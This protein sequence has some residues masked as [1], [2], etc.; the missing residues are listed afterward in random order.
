[1]VGTYT[2]EPLNN[3]VGEVSV[4]SEIT[5]VWLISCCSLSPSVME[6]GGQGHSSVSIPSWRDS[7]Q[8]VWST[9]SRLSSLPAS[10]EL[11]SFLTL[12]VPPSSC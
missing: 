1:M 12:Y 4:S 8:R 9:S 6:W 3:V 5:L 10:S 11:A 7:R 2:V